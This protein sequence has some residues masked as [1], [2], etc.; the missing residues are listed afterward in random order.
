MIKQGTGKYINKITRS[1]ILYD[2]QKIALSRTTLLLKKILS[3]RVSNM[4]AP[5][6]R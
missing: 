6:G 3:N 4:D 5:L 1:C 2:I